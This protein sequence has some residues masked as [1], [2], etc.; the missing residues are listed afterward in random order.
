MPPLPPRCR[1][2]PLASLP[3]QRRLFLQRRLPSRLPS[4]RLPP[5]QQQVHLR[6][7]EPWSTRRPSAPTAPG[8]GA[9]GGPP[10]CCRAAPSSPA[11]VPASPAASQASQDLCPSSLPAAVK[12]LPQAAEIKQQ[13][14][15]LVPHA[16]TEGGDV[17]RFEFD[18]PSPDDAVLAAQQGKGP[19]RPP[20][21]QQ[22]PQQPRQQQQRG[23]A[24]AAVGLDAGVRGL[25]LNGQQPAEGAA[26]A[27]DAAAPLQRAA[28]R[29]RRPLADYRP[30]DE[31]AA[32]CAA[33]AA[34]EAAGGG[35]K[36]RLHLVVL[37]HVD[38]GKSTLMGRTLY[39]LGLLSERAVQRTQR[40]AAAVGKAS[41]AWAWV[42]DER[43]E[44][45]A[46]GVTVDVAVTRCAGRPQRAQARRWQAG[47]YSS[48]VEPSHPPRASIHTLY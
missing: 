9:V 8:S 23:A 14:H 32:E 5:L 18:Q 1:P 21:K 47:W 39:E 12:P 4:R 30:D 28:P 6:W 13:A 26:P 10:L 29:R 27:G 44:E 22:Q 17:R 35:A 11:R 48:P 45:R 31:L 24:Q 3:L 15:R 42:L 46:R 36:P 40:E 20:A 2:Q 33:A 43:P 37:G 25:S 34:A 19:G 7:L 38:A 41:F 16:A